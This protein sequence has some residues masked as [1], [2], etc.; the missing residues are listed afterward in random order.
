MQKILFP[1]DFSD[2]SW[3]AIVYAF[4]FFK[5]KSL[6][7]HFLNVGFN[8]KIESSSNSHIQ[9]LSVSNLLPKNAQ[10]QLK[11]LKE[12]IHHAFPYHR[13]TIH[14]HFES[15]I[16][17]EGVRKVVKE[18]DIDLIIMGTKGAS[19]FK[20]ATVGSHA[21]S[22]IT[23]VKCPTFIIPEAASYINPSRIVFP[24]DFNMLYKSK[25]LRTLE[26][27]A[28]FHNSSVKILRV[29][30]KAGVLEQEQLK[31]RNFLGDSLTNTAHSFH[32][33]DSPELEEGLQE[34][35]TTMDINV[36]AMVGKNLNFFQRLIFKPSQ[37]KISYHTQIPFLVLHE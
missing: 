35:I 37:E 22:V 1:T 27:F 21:G 8:S 10:E 30:V 23:R 15:P 36:I 16:F 33:I 25:I 11:E 26:K 13:H 14:T 29:V 12:R 34:F 9:G 5:D 28:Q 6:H 17:I 4:S 7:F 20:E 18:M 2:N 31:N 32:K 24:T 19:G 3:N